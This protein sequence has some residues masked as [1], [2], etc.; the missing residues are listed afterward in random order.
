[1]VEV[2]L[3]ALLGVPF[4]QMVNPRNLACCG[5]ESECRFLCADCCLK[6]LH[7]DYLNGEHMVI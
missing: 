6:S 5:R 4:D 7:V 3:K 1:M 2:K